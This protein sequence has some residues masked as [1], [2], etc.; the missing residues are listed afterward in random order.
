MLPPLQEALAQSGLAHTQIVLIAFNTQVVTK[1]RQA[2]PGVP[3]LLLL[4]HKKGMRPGE[5]T[6]GIAEILRILDGLDATGLG[7]ASH[8]RVN[9]EF[10]QCMRRAGKSL[11]VWT[12]DKAEAADRYRRLG[13]DS[14]TTD[15]P[16]WLRAQMKRLLASETRPHFR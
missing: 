15:R 5:W 14:I 7:I 16:Q 10:V 13:V 2:L 6:P 8:P 12:V 3:A 1:A 9:R 4:D 11:N